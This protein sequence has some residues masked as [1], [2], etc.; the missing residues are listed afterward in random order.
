MMLNK[1]S[2][3]AQKQRHCEN[4]HSI[5]VMSFENW[6]P[7]KRVLCWKEQVR[8]ANLRSGQIPRH[9]CRTYQTNELP[10]ICK[11]THRFERI[12]FL[13]ANHQRFTRH[14][15]PFPMSLHTLARNKIPV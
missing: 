12:L 2:G 14:T 1:N 3:F 10:A 13:W 7:V 9:A 15:N 11:S 6:E 4:C 5:P 8:A